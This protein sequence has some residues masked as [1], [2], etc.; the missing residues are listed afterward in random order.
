[1]SEVVQPIVYYV[2]NA[3]PEPIRSALVEGASWW[4]DAFERA[5][6]RGAYEVLILPDDADPMD[7]RYNVVNWVHRSTRGWS[8]GEALTDPRTGE[9]LKG[10]VSLGS[11]RIR[12]DV[13]IASGL[14]APY[15]GPDPE[16]LATLDAS[17]SPT[18]LALAVVPKPAPAV[19][20]SAKSTKTVKASTR[21][22]VRTTSRA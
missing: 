19:A 13:A 17:V 16:V 9:I 2:D 8:Y 12:Q 7:V 18:E 11:L 1:M 6:F 22:P 14:V 3:A 20:K 4:K 21:R 5:G 10:N 15:E